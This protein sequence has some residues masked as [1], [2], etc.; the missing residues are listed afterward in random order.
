VLLAVARVAQK[1]DVQ[2][3]TWFIAVVMVRTKST[4][5]RVVTAAVLAMIRTY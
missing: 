4:T 1:Y 3:V 2:F 5:V